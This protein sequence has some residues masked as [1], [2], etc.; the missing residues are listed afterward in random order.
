MITASQRVQL[1]RLAAASAPAPNL[2]LGQ[3]S[4]P[5]RLELA[6]AGCLGGDVQAEAAAALCA[7]RQ[8]A[9]L[10]ELK[11][12]TSTAQPGTWAGREPSFRAFAYI[13]LTSSRECGSGRALWEPEPAGKVMILSTVV[14]IKGNEDLL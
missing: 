5:P 6:F 10:G 2:R 12:E 4:A 9:L 7:M 8:P 11:P 1:E 13:L 3:T 14:I